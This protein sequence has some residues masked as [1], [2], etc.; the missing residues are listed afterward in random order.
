MLDACCWMVGEVWRGCYEWDAD[1]R[2]FYGFTRMA[3]SRLDAISWQLRI[4]NDP[5]KSAKSVLIRVPFFLSLESVSV[6]V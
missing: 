1:S 6:V 2:G 5:W 3:S 4:P